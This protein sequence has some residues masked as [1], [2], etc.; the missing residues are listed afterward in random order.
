MILN[1]FL[2]MISNITIILRLNK[3]IEEE[4]PTDVQEDINWVPSPQTY[5]K[6]KK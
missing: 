2:L 5:R 1:G 3:K 6:N 4:L